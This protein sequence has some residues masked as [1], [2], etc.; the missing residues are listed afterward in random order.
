MDVVVEETTEPDNL[1]AGLCFVLQ[2]CDL[3][4]STSRW[5]RHLFL[6]L[7][8]LLFWK[9]IAGHTFVQHLVHISLSLGRMNHDSLYRQS[10][11]GLKT[12]KVPC[13]KQRIAKK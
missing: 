13:N 4:S 3:V 6:S 10:A 2:C 7:G 9:Y 11:L 8:F 1:S 5:W 12:A